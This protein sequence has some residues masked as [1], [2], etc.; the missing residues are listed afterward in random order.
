MILVEWFLWL[1]AYSFLGWVYESTLCSIKEKQIVNRGFL[2]SPV[3]PVYGFGSLALIFLLYQRIDNVVILFF[4]SMLITCIVE[5][6]TS[7]LL[8]KLFHA[9]WWDYSRHHFNIQGR[10]SLFVAMIFGTMS[11]VIIKYIHPFLSSKIAQLPDWVQIVFSVVIFILLM[12]DLYVTV[13][14]LLALKG[15]LEEVQSAI[16]EFLEEH[17]KRAGE[18]KHALL[19]KLEESEF[20]SDHIKSLLSI[21]KFHN[22]RIV[23]A[24]PKLR[25]IKYDDAWQK[26]K[27][28]LLG[29]DDT[30]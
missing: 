11:I 26:L 18:L 23:R 20:Y 25:Y 2:N 27:S 28:T 13:T 15:R 30:E 9:K 4:A 29:K 8:E 19:D 5:Y 3:C 12:V 21:N 14:H 24:F 7:V 17:A 16:N 1:I 22:R 6:A 10:V